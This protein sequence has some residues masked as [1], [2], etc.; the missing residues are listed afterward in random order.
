MATFPSHD[1]DVATDVLSTRQLNRA[2]LARQL[3]LERVELDAVAA[4]G[5]VAGVQAQEPTNPYVGL[6]SRLAGFD[7][8][9]LGRRLEDRTLVRS[10]CLR[11]TIHLVTADDCLTM[12]PL[13]RPTRQR[14]LTAHRDFAPILASIDVEPVLDFARAYLV[15]PRTQ[16]ELRA[17]LQERF[18]GVDPGA[19][20][21][22]IRNLLG[23]VQAPPRGVWGK[24]SQVI[25]VLIES[26]L[27]RPL[28]ADPSADDLVL[29]HLAAF[30]P[31]TPADVNVWCRIPGMAA[32]LERLAPK[33]RTFHDERGRTLWDVADG[34]LPD[35]D[36]PAPPRFLPE[37][38]NV[39]LSH[40]DRSRIVPPDLGPGLALASSPWRGWVLLDGMLRAVWHLDG[41]V[42]EVRHAG[43][44]SMASQRA[45]E[46]EGHDL[47]RFLG[48]DEPGVR[49]VAAG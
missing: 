1:G 39:L 26:W 28:H 42:V 10:A 20:T 9:E 34:L 17:A 47:A 18:P 16:R 8:V 4:V 19:L 33:L 27:G 37:Y 41:D 46:R 23:I 49:V 36:T 22:A 43:R 5:H 32:V 15:E 48:V 2:L 21:L 25:P 35:A 30:G 3:L 14:E 13:S 44:T 7:P 40:A 29:R 12:W 31:A 11:T 6:W 24:R 45:I 38:D